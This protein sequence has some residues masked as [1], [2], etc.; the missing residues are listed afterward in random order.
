MS[1]PRNPLISTCL[2]F[3]HYLSKHVFAT[4]NV[5]EEWAQTFSAMISGIDWGLG[6]E[7]GGGRVEEAQELVVI[8]G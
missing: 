2:A 1:L 5:K 8:N 7:E 6:R 3:E 4:T